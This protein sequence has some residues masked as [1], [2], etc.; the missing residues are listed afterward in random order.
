MNAAAVGRFRGGSRRRGCESSMDSLGSQ[1]SDDSH[2]TRDDSLDG[3]VG[4][5]ETLPCDGA[6]KM[7]KR[8]TIELESNGT[9]YHWTL[10]NWGAAQTA[11]RSNLNVANS[12]NTLAI[13]LNAGTGMS[14]SGTAN[15]VRVD[16]ASPEDI[17]LDT[18]SS[19]AVYSTNAYG[20]TV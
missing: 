1:T 19:R 9:S 10:S 12:S 3:I 16:L 14:G 5:S 4:T 6:A 11:R 8:A 17:S 7:G 13:G 20:T 15:T 2:L 18:D